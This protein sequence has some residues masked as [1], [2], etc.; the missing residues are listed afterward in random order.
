MRK[1]TDSD[2][3]PPDLLI[4]AAGWKRHVLLDLELKAEQK[5]T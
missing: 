4:C 2:Y 1:V 5:F 3:F